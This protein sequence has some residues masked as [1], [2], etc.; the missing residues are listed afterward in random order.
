M[1]LVKMLENMPRVVGIACRESFSDMLKLF[2]FVRGG[3]SSRSPLDPIISAISS[4]ILL[5]V[6]NFRFFANYLFFSELTALLD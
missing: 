2:F 3:G 4:L 5:H 1:A 6:F